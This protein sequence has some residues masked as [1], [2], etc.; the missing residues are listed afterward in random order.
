[1]LSHPLVFGFVLCLVCA[2]SPSQAQSPHLTTLSYN[3][4]Y[5]IG[6]DGKTDLAR[7]ARVI[8]DSK[9]G[10]VGLQEIGSKAMAKEL[11]RLADMPFVFGRSKEKDSQ[12]GDAILCRYPF[13]YVGNE[14]IPSASSSRYQAMA[15]DVDVSKVFGEGAS[16][17][18]VNTHFDWLKT[19]GSQEARLAACQVIERAFFQDYQGPA[20]LAGDLNAVPGSAPLRRL[21]E[22]G[23]FFTDLGEP[24]FTIGA[25]KPDRQIDYVLVRPKRAWQVRKLRVMDEPVASDH[26]PV[27]MELS[28][29]GR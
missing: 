4:H 1:M 25:P 16:V 28:L 21:G 12:Y 15:I 22:L 9:A 7:I 18:F 6:M 24:R 11:G 10:I 14:S 20:L 17:R 19:I 13:T 26:L 2:Q 29:Q 3:I 5:A 23:W 27:V 8:R